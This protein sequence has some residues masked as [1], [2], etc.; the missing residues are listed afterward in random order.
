MTTKRKGQQW[1]LDALTKYGG[2]DV[3]HP[4]IRGFFEEL[5]YFH[6]DIDRVFEKLKCARMYTKAWAT[7]A[8][9]VESKARFAE[10]RGWKTAARDLYARACILYARARYTYF[11]DDPRKMTLNEKVNQ[12]FKKV[13]S[14]NA[15]PI[16]RVALDFEGKKIY[17]ILHL[18]DSKEKSPVVIMGPGTDM[19]KEDWYRAVERYY[20]PRGFVA[21]SI[22]GPGQGETLT[23]GCK[24]SADNYDRAV[25][26]FIDYLVERP[27]VDPE[28]ISYFGVSTGSYWGF[29]AAL[30]DKRIKALA[31]AMGNIG[32]HW[33]GEY[34]LAQPNFKINFMYM[35]GYE[36]EDKFD[37]EIAAPMVLGERVKDM[38]CPSLIVHGEFDEL[39]PL[40][41]VIET[42]ES[43]DAPKEMWVMENEFHPLGPVASDWLSCIGDW[44]LQMLD[45]KYEKDM[46]R[47][48]F[49][50]KTGEILEGT[51]KP[52][53]WS[54]AS[55][56]RQH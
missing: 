56:P 40:E 20:L 53:W 5:G 22:D 21:L 37:R 49:W 47:R 7:T 13:I 36:D 55:P 14:F 41:H 44:L 1:I 38:T 3:L 18:N 54:G 16:E 43:I 11:S 4:E 33:E 31:T 12:S 27:E 9:E 30:Y 39:T 24:V 34:E 6:G 23:H 17:A 45:G 42:Y 51:V 48:L 46:D 19:F 52:P 26:T 15:T 2:W 28:K 50:G 29:S 8:Q 35:S 10:K 32:R 25:K